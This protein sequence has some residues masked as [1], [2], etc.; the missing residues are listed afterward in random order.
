MMENPGMKCGSNAPLVQP[1]DLCMV[2]HDGH[3]AQ[4]PPP[5]I[6]PPRIDRRQNPEAALFDSE[7]LFRAS[8]NHAPVAI[9][10]SRDG[11]HVYGNLAYQS[12][13]CVQMLQDLV[14]NPIT[15]LVAPSCRDMVAGHFRNNA[16]I[17][18]PAGKFEMTA[19]RMDGSQFYCSVTTTVIETPAGIATLAFFQD[20]TVQRESQRRLED[21]EAKSRSLAAH[22]L[23]A[24]EEERKTVAREIHDELGQ[25]LTAI[26]M[27]LQWMEK[28]FDPRTVPVMDKLQNV[29]ELVS[30]TIHMVHRISS[31]LRPVILDDLG[32]AAAIEWL[33]GDFSRRNGIHCRIDIAAPVSHI[34]GRR[35]IAL[36][37]IVQ[38]ALINIA[39]HAKASCASVELWEE[40]GALS[41]RVQDDGVGITVVQATDSGSFGLIGIRERVQGLHGEL[42][43][44]G[45]PGEGTTLMV[46][47]PLLEEGGSA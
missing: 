17:G 47:I 31:E 3:P 9:G 19:M 20:I 16:A 32:L 2:G 11:M 30:Q 46:V 27:G 38:E 12:M 33:G 34:V 1:E 39:H 21:S 18:L 22:L 6:P 28:R 24:R 37:R 26:K 42:S 36:Y 5:V 15:D 14:G 8:I 4:I 7:E 29:V 25:N 40:S 44:M 43:I 23:H 10:L 45:L 41:I 35:A 13:F